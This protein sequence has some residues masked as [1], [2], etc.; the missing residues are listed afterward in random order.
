MRWR[1]AFV[2]TVTLCALRTVSGQDIRITGV[3]WA[4]SIDLRP[5]RRDSVRASA[6]TGTGETRRGPQGQ[7]VNCVE[8]DTF[9]GFLTSRERETT[10]P[11]LQDLSVAAWGLG[12]GISLHAH[13]RVRE[14]LGASSASWPR[15]NDRFDVLDAYLELDRPRARVRLGR[16]WS[17]GG[18]GAYSFDGGAVTALSDTFPVPNGSGTVDVL[19]FPFSG[20]SSAGLH[21]YGSTN[22]YF[23]SRSSGRG[24]YDVTGSFH[25]QNSFTNSG[26]A[27]INAIFNFFITPGQLSLDIGAA[28]TGASFAEAGLTFD[29]KR[30]GGSIW[31]SS[32]MLRGDAGGT[33]FSS[34]GTNL[35]A[36]GGTYYSIN[37][38][39]QSIDLGVVNANQ[40]ITI[41]YELD[42]YA[43][44]NSTSGADRVV[45]A[46]SYFVPDQWIEQT[47]GGYE[48][49]FAFVGD[50]ECIPGPPVFVPGHIVEVPSYTV[51]GTPSGSTAQSG[52]PFDIV[53]F[54]F[55]DQNGIKR[56]FLDLNSSI[57]S[58]A[59]PIPEPTS[60]ALMLAA[61]GIFG[62]NQGRKR[63][64]M[65]DTA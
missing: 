60:L 26:P 32:A 3:T 10:R 9:C 50:G 49:A 43:K 62:W 15:L 25:I 31:G 21:S 61:L 38:L 8:G 55:D 19:D 13:G 42:T 4:Q 5:L 12:Q 57:G 45:P 11:L 64:L 56:G 59:Q 20:S 1:A 30:D 17:L 18:L 29:L 47:C 48:D 65:Q 34:T 39:F 52:D 14:A 22:G 40:T 37:G 51:F 46:T 63:A 23:G 27:A 36:G 35:Y 6:T 7:L 41:D 2:V 24:E 28:F 54:F 33:T 53:G 44:G 16:Q 58:S